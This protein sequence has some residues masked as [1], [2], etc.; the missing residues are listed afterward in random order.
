MAR[1]TINTKSE[2]CLVL[3]ALLTLFVS[4][5][6]KAELSSGASPSE[7][8]SPT[9]ENLERPNKTYRAGEE[10]R[11]GIRIRW[12]MFDEAIRMSSPE[13]SLE[14]LELLGVKQETLST[15]DNQESTKGIEQV[16]TFRFV[17]A[18]SGRAAIKS[19]SLHWTYA[20]GII[21]SSLS[22]PPV[23]FKITSSKSSW[24]WPVV[25]GGGGLAIISSGI[26][27]FLLKKK[28]Q[29]PP[30]KPPLSLEET[31]LLELLEIRK[32]WESTNTTQI[33]LNELTHLFE[34]YLG[35]KLDWNLHQDGYNALHHKAEGKWSRK[36]A[37]E[38]KEI[39]Q[40]LEYQRF[41]GAATEGNEPLSL[42][43]KID[44]FIERK[45]VI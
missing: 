41:A 25:I 43:Q 37:H 3:F 34:D 31:T 5:T 7:V 24:L 4:A 33:F 21:S 38:I 20:E 12:P 23:E 16:L 36:E 8:L 35:R 19:F 14:N 28:I 44:L 27:V 11:Y 45:K 2:I 18:E 32:K 42:Y 39:F 26:F 17:A 6:V 29:K 40:A 22:I 9:L 13:L 30:G 10:I 15:A 1:K